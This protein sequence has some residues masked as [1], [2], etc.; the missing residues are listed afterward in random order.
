MPRFVRP[1][2]MRLSADGVASKPAT[3][4]RTR[5][6][7]LTASLTLRTATGGVSED[8]RLSAGGRYQDGT[9]RA[10][11][12]IPQGFAVSVT[13]ADGTE[14][15]YGADDIRALDIRPAIGRGIRWARES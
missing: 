8:I 4:P 7:W 5:D 12:D 2:Y 1:A 9:G 10:R 11:F 3:G 14:T 15:V 6:G 13:A